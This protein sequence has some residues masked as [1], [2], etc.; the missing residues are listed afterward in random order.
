MMPKG[1]KLLVIRDAQLDGLRFVSN[2]VDLNCAFDPVGRCVVDL[3]VE[4]IRILGD[5]V[6]TVA[7]RIETFLSVVDFPV[8]RT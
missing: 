8:E 4:K 3:H 2:L 1:N 5:R 6:I 7:V